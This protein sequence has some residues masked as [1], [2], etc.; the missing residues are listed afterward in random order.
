M[1]QLIHAVH[2][3]SGGVHS[4]VW[5]RWMDVHGC[6]GG[7]CM[8]YLMQLAQPSQRLSAAV[9]QSSMSPSQYGQ[10]LALL[11]TWL[12]FTCAGWLDIANSEF[13]HQH[14]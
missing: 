3:A 2:V 6:R 14:P 12:S 10:G 11:C 9:R 4:R 7:A 5:V 13:G 8:A 1:K